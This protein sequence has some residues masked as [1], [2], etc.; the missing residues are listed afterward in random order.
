[1]LPENMVS[2]EFEVKVVFPV[3]FVVGGEEKVLGA[4]IVGNSGTCGL[5]PITGLLGVGPE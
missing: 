2:V 4:G 1:M 5:L 3:I